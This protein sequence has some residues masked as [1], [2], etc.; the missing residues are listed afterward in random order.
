MP[1]AHGS[2]TSDNPVKRYCQ[3]LAAAATN[4]HFGGSRRY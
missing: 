4:R 1:L 3:Q 2:D